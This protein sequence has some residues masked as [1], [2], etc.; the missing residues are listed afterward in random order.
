M[1]KIAVFASGRGT[2]FGNIAERKI[3][4]GEISLLITD[5]ICPALDI[6]QKYSI[7]SATF[8]R[9]SFSSKQEM[10]EAIVSRLE[11]SQI[12]LIVLAGYMR[13]LS[14]WFVQRYPRRII[15]IHPSLLPH[16]KGTHAIEQAFE[17]GKGL[18]GVSVHY[19]NEGMD[20]GELIDQVRIS[21][22]GDDL[23]ELETMV[24]EAEYEI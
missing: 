23:E 7:E 15:N 5:K 20:E 12:D 3:E 4:K 17:D 2:N 9:K 19:V 13:L 6:A 21:Y 22:N 16:Y 1:T 18:Y 10:E 8:L 14:P 24:H 11:K